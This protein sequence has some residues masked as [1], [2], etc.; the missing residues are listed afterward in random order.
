[1]AIIRCI[2]IMMMMIIQTGHMDTLLP[3]V[4]SIVLSIVLHLVV[5]YVLGNAHFFGNNDLSKPFYSNFIGSCSKHRP[6]WFENYHVTISDQCSV[7]CVLCPINPII[8]SRLRLESWAAV[9]SKTW[10]LVF[11]CL[12]LVLRLGARNTKNDACCRL[13]CLVWPPPHLPPFSCSPFI[14]FWD[15]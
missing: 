11:E 9:Q 14:D 8:V 15:G 7:W 5:W 13:M 2:N 4:Q 10:E 12:W 3:I 6:R 1:M